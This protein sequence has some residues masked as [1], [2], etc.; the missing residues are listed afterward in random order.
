MQFFLSFSFC[1]CVSVHVFMCKWF[2]CFDGVVSL[3][4]WSW[5]CSTG[6]LACRN[7]HVAYNVRTR[8]AGQLWMKL[9]AHEILETRFFFTTLPGMWTCVWY[10]YR[11]CLCCYYCC[12]NC[13][14]GVWYFRLKS[15]P[16][17][18]RLAGM[19]STSEFLLIMCFCHTLSLI[20]HRVPTWLLVGQAMIS[21]S[22]S[23][24]AVMH[25]GRSSVSPYKDM[26]QINFTVPLLLGH[27]LGVLSVS[28]SQLLLQ[29][30]MSQASCYAHPG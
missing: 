5:G 15:W 23:C 10:D 26:R 3:L 25:L 29:V 28:Q 1:V 24:F 7:V 11:V 4:W 14:Q 19:M 17:H 16:C 9:L 27:L 18:A 12:G 30:Q 2:L 8:N 6:M 13:D 20:R 22:L 21:V